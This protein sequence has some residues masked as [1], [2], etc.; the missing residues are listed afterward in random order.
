MSAN[1]GEIAPP[2]NGGRRVGI[3]AVRPAV[4]RW[5]DYARED[6][7]ADPVFVLCAARTGSTLLRFLLDAHP[8]LA[9]PPETDLPLL[10]AQLA[11]TWS[12]LAGTPLQKS[13]TGEP[14]VLADPL[15][16]SIRS[17]MGPMIGQHLARRGKKRLCDKS[18]STAKHA[19]LLLQVFPGAKFI[20]LYR[21]PM[22]MI[23]SG[24]EAC[25]WGLQGFG[26]DSYAA[27]CPGS[28]VLA[29][30]RYWTEHTREIRAVEERYPDKCHRVR[31]EDLVSDP[32]AVT[33]GIFRFLEVPSSPRISVRCFSPERERLGPGDYK[34]WRTSRITPDSVGR[35]WSIPVDQIEP[36]ARASLN[37]IAGELGYVQVDARWSV[38]A[39]PPDLRVTGNGA[40]PLASA[41]DTA[42]TRAMPRWVL[43]LGDRLQA[44][45][46]GI[47]DRFTGRW[48]P[49]AK[50]SFLV[51]ATSAADGGGIARWRVDLAARTVTLAG[52]PGEADGAVSWQLTGSDATWGQVL[53]GAT[54]LNVALRHRD[55]RYCDT[56][57]VPAS[58][59]VARIDMLADLLGI[60]SWRPDE[61]PAL[62]RAFPTLAP[63]AALPIQFQG[64]AV[65]MSNKRK[66][67]V[68]APSA[69]VWMLA[70]GALGSVA[71]AGLHGGAGD[72]TSARPVIQTATLDD[73][74]TATQPTAAQP[75]AAQATA[76]QPTAPQATA[77][78]SVAPAAPQ[79]AGLVGSP[80]SGT[81]PWTPLPATSFP[82]SVPLPAS[83]PEPFI[84]AVGVSGN[85]HPGGWGFGYSAAADT[86]W[87]PNNGWALALNVGLGFGG[88]DFKGS[89]FTSPVSMTPAVGLT[90]Q[91]ANPLPSPAVLDTPAGIFSLSKLA[92]SVTLGS[93]G[94]EGPTIGFS[95]SVTETWSLKPPSWVPDIPGKPQL[96]I[97]MTE[98]PG[99]VAVGPD[100]DTQVTD[101]GISDTFSIKAGGS[102]T[103]GGAFIKFG[104]TYLDTVI[105]SNAV[106][107]ANYL[108]AY[109][110]F[111]PF[112]ADKA[113]E[114]FPTDPQTVLKQYF[115]N[116]PGTE[117][118]MPASVAVPGVDP[119]P[120][121][122][123][124][125]LPVGTLAAG[126]VDPITQA[127][128][129]LGAGAFG[130]TPAGQWYALPGGQG[131]AFSPATWLPAGW[132]A[133][134]TAAPAPA[135][136]SWW[137]NAVTAT[138]NNF[139]TLLYGPRPPLEPEVDPISNMPS[140]GSASAPQSPDW[141]P[142]A[143][144][145]A[146][147]SASWSQQFAPDANGA[148]S[149]PGTPLFTAPAPGTPGQGT[150]GWP[151]MPVLPQ[152][153]S[154]LTDPANVAPA[155]TQ[156]AAATTDTQ[157][158]P[159]GDKTAQPPAVE[160]PVVQAPDVQAPAAPAQP[161]APGT[162]VAS[163]APADP[164]PADQPDTPQGGGAAPT[165]DGQQIQVQVTDAYDP[166]TAYDPSAAIPS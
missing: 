104:A 136:A 118:T 156:F 129:S 67:P 84:K 105:A 148:G 74:V 102:I 40:V 123:S 120:F 99:G 17:T 91:F 5:S 79:P 128:P 68:R 125:D 58:V 48:A 132:T 98:S 153:S 61:E 133:T 14:A 93:W 55:L 157:A 71:T 147:A 111:A 6:D 51:L 97:S 116:F 50:D 109:G 59:T 150:T 122:G 103:S 159:A 19:S 130:N 75:T 138:V 64:V 52:R 82:E 155:A 88:V 162:V 12:I 20:C 94:D 28:D 81:A 54:N 53:N 1:P 92:G 115:P 161:A 143:Q 101:G 144:P 114:L 107:Q 66:V 60:T 78:P 2:D 86:T 23:A 121:L 142:Q 63:P 70:A 44:G 65:I 96:Q 124:A 13:R 164:P 31:Y 76:A 35:G 152:K 100:L 8:D 42:T 10:C 165:T 69:G 16:A 127:P 83:A 25:P 21:H 166:G 18:M 112:Y 85:V 47:S 158:A 72:A 57:T 3:P 34:I 80:A 15:P 45:V 73:S 110:L 126:P 113:E 46:F 89:A 119:V 140:P 95:P 160:A 43:Q 117:A 37:E 9:C 29:L 163:A 146:N 77:A 62:L 141:V 39:T 106:A 26:F 27:S 56:G 149:M 151:M 135:P 131:D 137:Q 22:D 30:A 4:T 41:R 49:C 33:D 139:S 32:E 145:P 11:K 108:E 87:A 36:Q 38:A 90:G 7:Q 134:P 24:I 154:D